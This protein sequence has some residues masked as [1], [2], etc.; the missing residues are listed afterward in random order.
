MLLS[1]SVRDF[2]L[3]DRLDLSFRSG[4]CVMTG[5]TGAGKSILLDALGL[6]LGARADAAFVRHGHLL[7][8]VRAVHTPDSVVLIAGDNVGGL[9]IFITKLTNVGSLASN[10]RRS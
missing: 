2:V 7:D 6:V 4:L 8:S 1:L 5:E 9:Q 3:I 10:C